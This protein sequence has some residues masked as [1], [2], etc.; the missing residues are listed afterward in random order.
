MHGPLNVKFLLSVRYVTVNMKI[1][2]NDTMFGWFLPMSC[3][4]NLF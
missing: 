4:W 3:E 2:N 1:Q